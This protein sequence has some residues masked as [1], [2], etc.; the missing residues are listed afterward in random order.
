MS[1]AHEWLKVVYFTFCIF[2]SAKT[3]KLIAYDE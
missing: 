2:P 3:E 1:E